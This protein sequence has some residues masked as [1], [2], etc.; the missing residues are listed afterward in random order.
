MPDDIS[1]R[2]PRLSLVPLTQREARAFI[3]EHGVP[4]GDL[5]RVGAARDGA[6]VAVAV[7]GRPVA[8]HLQD[9]YTAEVIRL[10]VAGQEHNACS[11]LLGACWRAARALG[12]RRLVTYTLPAEGGASLRASGWRCVGE[13]GGGSWSCPS[14]PRVDTHPTQVKLRWEAG[15]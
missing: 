5:F 10:C 3:A 15:P 13:A 6:I 1:D 9:G 12:Y 4:R 11:F 2:L 14:R 7:V 8:R